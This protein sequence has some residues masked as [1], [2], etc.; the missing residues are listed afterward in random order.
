M[1]VGLYLGLSV[2]RQRFNLPTIIYVN[3]AQT[4]KYGGASG[5]QRVTR[6]LYS[7]LD[8]FELDGYI[9]QFGLLGPGGWVVAK[10]YVP[11]VSLESGVVRLVKRAS[12]LLRFLLP[13]FL[14]KIIRDIYRKLREAPSPQVERDSGLPAN[15]I[16]VEID[17]GWLEDVIP[18]IV[19]IKRICLIYDVIPLTHSQ[20]CT[21]VHVDNFSEWFFNLI[22]KSSGILSI[23]KSALSDVRLHASRQVDIANVPSE[24]FYLGGDFKPPKQDVKLSDNFSFLSEEKYFIVVG[25]VEPRKNHL[26]LV[27]AYEHYRSLGGNWKLVIVGRAGWSCSEIVKAIRGSKYFNSGLYWFDDADD[28][29]L[30][31]LYA[32]SA[33]VICPSFAEGFGLP[34][35]EGA[36]MRKPVI[37]SKINVF[38]ELAEEFAYFF[39]PDDFAALSELMTC[40]ERDGLKFFDDD[41]LPA[42]IISWDQSARNFSKGVIEIV[43]KF[44]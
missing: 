32:K 43:K 18:D 5:I 1:L 13:N 8:S 40:A 44:D 29:L 27:K 42:E 10:N 28:T 4:L 12:A 34:V 39:E 35:V 9:F 26:T 21:Q 23:S 38:V 31:T 19:P 33:C 20:F 25:T 6:E 15:S 36:I 7:R 11:P 16:L 41:E 24:F 3:I 22:R 30:T 17:A 37:A 14:F 2:D